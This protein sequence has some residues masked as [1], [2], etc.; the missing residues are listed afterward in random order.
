MAWIEKIPASRLDLIEEE[1]EE[2]VL[3]RRSL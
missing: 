3:M 1:E 2:G